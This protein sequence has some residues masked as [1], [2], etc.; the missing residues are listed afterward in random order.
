MDA[1]QV[2][3]KALAMDPDNAHAHVGVC[4]MALRRKQFG[5]AAQSRS[6]RC[7]G[8]ITV[9]WRT[10]FRAWRWA[11]GICASGRCDAGGHFLQ[12]EFS[13]RARERS[14]EGF[15]VAA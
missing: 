4:R 5:V 8:F 7:S 13:P 12:A 15:V 3:L 11:E 9:L 1:E 14:V 2:Y 10:S 6:M